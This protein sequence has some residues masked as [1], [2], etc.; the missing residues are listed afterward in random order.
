VEAGPAHEG[1]VEEERP[2]SEGQGAPGRARRGGV[3]RHLVLGLGVLV[4]LV[5]VLADVLGIGGEP[6]FG[7]DALGGGPAS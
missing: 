6:G 3:M 1:L 5:S 4:A 2:S 7:Y